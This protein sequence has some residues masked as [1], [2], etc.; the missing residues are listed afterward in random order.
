M[1]IGAGLMSLMT[2]LRY[3][4]AWWPLHPIGY[5]LAY[6][7]ATQLSF[8]AIFVGW[9]LKFVII[10][11]GGADLYTRAKPFFY[12]VLIGG[13][14]LCGISLVLDAIWFPQQGHQVYF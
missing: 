2:Y 11:L 1:G 8:G 14:V 9:L 3:R 6:A 13:V 5:T 7:R 4:F 12:G 10:K